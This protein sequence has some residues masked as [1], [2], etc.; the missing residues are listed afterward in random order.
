MNPKVSVCLITYNHEPFISQALDGT[1][2][3]ETDFDFEIVIGDDCSTDA[4]QSIIADY[5]LKYPDKIRYNRHSKNIGMIGNWIHTIQSCKGDYI[6]IIEGDDYWTSPDKLRLQTAFLDSHS[7]YSMCFHRLG[8]RAENGVNQDDFYLD[9]NLTKTTYTIEDV[10]LN[11]WFIGSCSMMV[12]NG[13]WDKFPDGIFSL[14]AI[15]KII[16]LMAGDK[17]LIGFIDYEMGIYRIHPQGLSQQQWLGK[18]NIFE[19][20]LIDLYQV[21]D[22]FSRHKYHSQIKQRIVKSFLLLLSKNERTSKSYNNALWGLMKCNPLKAIG[23]IRDTIIVHV[24]PKK[25]YTVYC[26]ITFKNR[27]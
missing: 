7:Q 26:S 2:K 5:L 3:Q 25:L 21:F 8:F 10:I 23:I 12:R 18:E 19:F 27:D 4:T 14:K 17:G 11:K 20:A 15:D 9:Q 16:Q 13:Y 22:S 1:L 6:A 24:I